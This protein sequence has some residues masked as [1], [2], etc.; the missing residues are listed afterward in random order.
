MLSILKYKKWVLANIKSREYI[1][2]C[3]LA[4][5]LMS[6]EKNKWNQIY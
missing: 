6:G 3:N 1:K 5:I 4:E 2:R